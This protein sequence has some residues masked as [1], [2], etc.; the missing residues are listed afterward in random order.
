MVSIHLSVHVTDGVPGGSLRL[1]RWPPEGA[2]VS[3]I[4]LMVRRHRPSDVTNGRARGAVPVHVNRHWFLQVLKVV[5]GGVR[6]TARGSLY[7]KAVGE[8]S[9]GHHRRIG[10]DHAV[11]APQTVDLILQDSAELVL[12][13]GRICVPIN[14]WGNH[15]VNLHEM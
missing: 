15:L 7:R 2:P 5:D 4:D 14:L 6:V 1:Q 12:H 3:L 9:V 10:N 11:G 8:V 13:L